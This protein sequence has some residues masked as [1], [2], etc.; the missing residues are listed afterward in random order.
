MTDLNRF[1]TPIFPGINDQPVEATANKAGNGADLINRVNG[2]INELSQAFNN[3]TTPST[4]TNDSL[5]WKIK[6]LF[7]NTYARFE[8]YFSNKSERAIY[9]ANTSET[10]LSLLNADC[11]KTFTLG[12]DIVDSDMMDISDVI[13]KCGVGYYFLLYRNNDGTLKTNCSAIA[14]NLSV[15]GAITPLDEFIYLTAT[16]DQYGSSNVVY[17]SPIVV[18]QVINKA[19]IVTYVAP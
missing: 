7:E 15:K 12:V 2:L 17:V 6:I 13:Q 16:N 11:I 10:A 19:T 4:P 9:A 14:A 18:K 8:V 3:N 1:K 5:D